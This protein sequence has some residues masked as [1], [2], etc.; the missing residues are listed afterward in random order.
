MARVARVEFAGE[1]D[2][3]HPV[4]V[5]VDEPDHQ[6]PPQARS[7]E[8]AGRGGIDPPNSLPLPA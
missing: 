5:M 1:G 3:R 4:I 2:E 8:L 7:D 6:E